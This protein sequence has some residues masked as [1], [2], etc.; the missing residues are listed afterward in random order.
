[1]DQ[2]EYSQEQFEYAQ[3]LKALCPDL[4]IG[5]FVTS[6]EHRLLMCCLRLQRKIFELEVKLGEVK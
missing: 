6:N 1:M 5:E 3:E 4:H 2:F